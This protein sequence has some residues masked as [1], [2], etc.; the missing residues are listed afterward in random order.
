MFGE[1]LKGHVGQEQPLHSGALQLVEQD[2]HVLPP[3]GTHQ[4]Q[5]AARTQR[6]EDLLEGHVEGQHRELLGD[7]GAAQTTGPAL[8]VQQVAQRA[9]GDI[10]PLGC[11][12]GARGEQR[13]QRP[14]AL[15]RRGLG[16]F[17]H[18]R[19]GHGRGGHGRGGGGQVDGAPGEAR[20]RDRVHV[21]LAARC[22]Q[23]AQGID[24]PQDAAQQG[25]RV[26]GVEGTTVRLRRAAASSATTC[27]TEGGRYS[28]IR[29]GAPGSAGS[30]WWRS[31]SA[32]NSAACASSSA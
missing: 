21:R 14:E 24:L 25:R 23:D 29:A 11:S 6:R 5:P 28:A 3:L 13:V 20:G 4:V 17:G 8:P 27:S 31:S 26:G 7:H 1:E 30:G 16:R 2:R 22:H 15:V 19:C 9:V 18:E 12:G 32:A 10:D